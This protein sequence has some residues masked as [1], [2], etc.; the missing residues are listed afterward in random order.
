VTCLGVTGQSVGL[1]KGDI[2][3]V[4]KRG[5]E[6]WPKTPDRPD[7]VESDNEGRK[8]PFNYYYFNSWKHPEISRSHSQPREKLIDAMLHEACHAHSA[9]SRRSLNEIKVFFRS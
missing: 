7:P 2:N 3:G 9:T 6:I 1:V 8:V 5:V 4:F